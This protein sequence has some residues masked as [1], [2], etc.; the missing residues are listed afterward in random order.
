MSSEPRTVTL[1]IE[2]MTCASCVSKVEKA[3]RS[4]D[5]VL[6]CRVNLATRTAHVQTTSDDAA[7]MIKAVERIG[8][9]AHEQMHDHMGG[10]PSAEMRGWLRLLLVAV[11]LTIA[12]L[13]LTFG[14]GHR[15]WSMPVAWALAT[16]VQ[17]YAGW[18]FLRSAGKAARHLS[19]TMDTL[20]AV[21]SLASYGY[22]VMAVLTDRHEHYFDTGAVIITLI[23]LGKV[24]ES[25][26]RA[27]AGDAA[28]SL[29]ECGAKEA[30]VLERAVVPEGKRTLSMAAPV[31]R[32]VAVDEVVVGDLVVVRPGEKIPVDGV[33]R[34]GSS[35]VDLS[36]LTGEPVPVDVR[37][38]DEVVGASI[39]GQGRL[40]IETTRV[41]ADSTLASIVRLLRDAQGS[42]APVQRLADRISSVFV[43]IVLALAALTFVGWSWLSDAGPGTALIHAVAVVLIACPC[44]LGL[45]TPAAI[46]AGS[47]RAAELG[48]LFKGGEVFEQARQLDVVLMDKTGTI[49]EGEMTLA[50]VQGEPQ[51][52]ALAAAVEAGSEHPIARAVVAGAQARGISIAA[53]SDFQADP[54]AGAHA[55]VDG[56]VVRVGRVGEEGRAL[57]QTGLTVFGVW[58][59]ERL[60]GVLGV[61]DRVKPDAA[62]TI[63][64]LHSMGY[65]VGMVTGDRAEA[66]QAVAQ[67]VG[68]DRVVAGVLPQGKI[69]EIDR[70]Q[71]DGRR[72]AFVGDGINDSPALARADLGIALGTGADVALEAADVM[73]LGGD[74]A[75]VADALRLARKTYRVIAQ[76]LGWAFGYNVVMIPLAVAGV[77][78]PELAA[79]AMA[80]SSV[81]VVLNALRLRRFRRKSDQPT[82]GRP[83]R[84]LVTTG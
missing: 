66:A 42:K 49:T 55:T 59:D 41:G 7:P 27:A 14:L 65:E 18:P 83:T 29:L 57:A 3:L 62:A 2:G 48:V 64:R 76:N 34:E 46:M 74:V 54:G 56:A 19:S 15:S 72:V 5:D 11:P 51:T 63:A 82:V 33:V 84:E 78:T 61:S 17:F 6:D 21:G 23:L 75:V 1:D 13:I 80:A 50:E 60:L 38:G 79:G 10:D 39:N 40:V 47:G 69:D 25:R 8:Y 58:Q 20:I 36:M 37:T 53:A 32:R 22:S 31:E 43:P 30:T 12:L 45:A 67:Q 24:L 77:L 52:L 16:P 71:R 73:V 28:R 35:S 26:A 44:A 9:G 81:S 4:S 68:I 70:L